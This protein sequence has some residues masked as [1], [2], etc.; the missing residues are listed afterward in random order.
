MTVQWNYLF[1]AS[2][3][4]ILP[5]IVLFSFIERHVVSADRGFRQAAERT[6]RDC[7]LNSV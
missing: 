1:A 2:V 6:S 5:V 3:V 4:A 7:L